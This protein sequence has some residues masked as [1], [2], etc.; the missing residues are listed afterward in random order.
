MTVLKEAEERRW[1]DSR[2]QSVTPLFPGQDMGPWK[3]LSPQCGDCSQAMSCDPVL[4]EGSASLL[5]GARC[6][7]EST[8]ETLERGRRRNS[9]EHA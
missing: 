4:N 3:R 9:E 6:H 8:F 1:N 7:M 5:R 2:G